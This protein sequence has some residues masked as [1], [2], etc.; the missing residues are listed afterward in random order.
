LNRRPQPFQGCALPAE[1][2]H[3]DRDEFYRAGPFTETR[4]AEK[5]QERLAVVSPQ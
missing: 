5:A 4:Q 2:S 3:R 1:L